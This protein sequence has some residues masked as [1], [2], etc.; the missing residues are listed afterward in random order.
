MAGGVLKEGRFVRLNVGETKTATAAATGQP[1]PSFVEKRLAELWPRHRDQLLA[2]LEARMAERTKNLETYLEER[3]RNEVAK[4]TAVLTELE[5]TIRK[6]LA[7]PVQL[8]LDLDL[9][10]ANLIMSRCFEEKG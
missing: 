10:G 8:T 1:A 5:R 6:E 3:A 7:D 4:L 9:C 2:A